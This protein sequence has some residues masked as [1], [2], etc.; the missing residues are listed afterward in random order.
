M[1]LAFL[2]P[3]AWAL[4]PG[5]PA[6]NVPVCTAA[7]SQ[8]F[9]RSISDGAGGAII[10]WTDSRNGSGTDDIYVAHILASGGVDPA[11]AMDGVA[12]CTSPRFQQ[13]PAIVSD[14]AGGAIVA[15][16][17]TRGTN[18][19][20]YAQHILAS[21]NI[22]PA[23][24]VN[25]L[26][27]GTG[28]NF[29]NYPVITSDG[30]GGAIVA[31]DESPPMGGSA[32]IVAQ[33]VLVSGSLDPAWPGSGLMVCD[34]ANY[35][36][37]PD[38]VSDGAG[39]A[40]VTWKD[41]RGGIG[42][43]DIYAQH[44]LASG[45]ADAA[46][47]ANGLALCAAIG[48]QDPPKIASD[49]SGG[50]IVTWSDPRA[51]NTGYYGSPNPDIYAQ[52]VLASG[53][54]D[55]AWPVNGRL[56]CGAPNQQYS[57]V[58]V[59]DDAGG[60]F[61]SWE[62]GRVYGYGTDIYLQ[63]VL[64]SGAVD[65]AWPV[66]GVAVSFAP[67]NEFNPTIVL[68]GS[69][70]AI[71]AWDQQSGFDIY[72]QHVL[73]SGGV[74]V[75]WPAGGHPVCTAANGQEK[76]TMVSDGAGGAILA[77]GDGRNRGA[78]FFT[79]I[80]SQRLEASGVLSPAPAEIITASAGPGGSISPAGTIIVWDGGSQAFTMTAEPCYPIADVIVDGASVGAVSSYTFSNVTIAHT[81]S[82]TFGVCPRGNIAGRVT[83]QCPDAGTPLLGV[84]V[85][86]FAVGS[87]DLV[88][89]GVTDAGGNYSISDVPALPYMV[90]LVT[91]LG[92]STPSADVPTTV[93]TGGTV[94]VD[95]DLNC[96]MASG[97]PNTSGFWKHQFGVAAGGNGTAQF[98][99]SALCDYLDMIELHFNNNALNQ[100][101]VY[102]PA[103]GATCAQKLD[104]GKSLLNLGGSAA[105]ID[106]AR[107]QL[108]SLLLNVA[109][110]DLTLNDSSSKDGATVSQAITYCDQIIDN[111]L[112]DYGL[113]A[114]IAEKINSGQKVNAGVIPLNTQSIAYAMGR[115]TLEFTAGRNPAT[116]P[117]TFSFTLGAPAKV[118][119]AIY[120]VQGRRVAQVYSGTLSEGRH[121]LPWSG[122]GTRGEKLGRGIYF[123]RLVAGG[124]TQVAKLVQTT[125]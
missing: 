104:L 46:W 111:P 102:G 16:Y 114:A 70:G 22:D 76:S 87:G 17:D 9:P 44:V 81:I 15:W 27:V 42:F 2:A 5:S 62:D 100:V 48:N 63:H 109:A 66:N 119:L 31:W 4:V 43:V 19:D 28:P 78:T 75:G 77:W 54:V 117:R 86:A 30:A 18:S 95:F 84:T 72:A 108:L 53:A 60:A 82:V 118:D 37:S 24:P 116:G 59:A 73:G 14:G 41:Q 101:V 121:S 7:N 91:P 69:G 107:Q 96:V 12:L 64:G 49:G 1:F 52:R 6:L 40:I 125:P 61:V 105:P 123:S 94:N 113:A 50:A 115:Q 55:P 8:N 21:G 83:A 57:P 93:P 34:A 90:S 80:Y 26:G 45:A 10:A 88:G 85:D 32:D 89:S 68:D 92:F 74:D 56:L 120:D 20:I 124:Q 35:Q 47:P 13:G 29:T 103:G 99:A 11:W 71:V 36:N 110:N 38:I 67:S 122:A 51:G 98:D 3:P 58:I 33:H 39:G 25:G 79:D 23:W 65:G 106:K 112:G 97:K